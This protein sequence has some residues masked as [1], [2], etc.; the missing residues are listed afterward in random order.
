VRRRAWAILAE[1]AIR[2]RRETLCVVTLAAGLALAVVG[3]A[4]DAAV[5]LAVAA[6]VLLAALAMVA[7]WF[8]EWQ[9]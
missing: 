2:A 3:V 6:V 5:A 7:A 9:A 4:V 1:S 8:M